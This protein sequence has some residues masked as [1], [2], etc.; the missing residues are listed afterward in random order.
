MSEQS[1]HRILG[2]TRAGFCQSHPDPF[3]RWL[4]VQPSETRVT[5]AGKIPYAY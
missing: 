2:A 5:D 1:I 3:V 4:T